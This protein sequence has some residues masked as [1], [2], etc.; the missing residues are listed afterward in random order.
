MDL[1]V[2]QKA[3]NG[4]DA[5]VSLAGLPAGAETSVMPEAIRNTVIAMREHGVKRL[6]VQ[7]GGFVKLKGEKGTILE[8]GAR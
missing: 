7:M 2:L 1:Q 3:C 8:A 6:I 5:V 4:V